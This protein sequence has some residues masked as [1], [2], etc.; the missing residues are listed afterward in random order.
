[1]AVVSMFDTPSVAAPPADVK[2]YCDGQSADT[3]I[4]AQ[5]IAREHDAQRQ[6]S[7]GVQDQETRARC[8]SEW[9]SWQ[10]RQARGGRQGGDSEAVCRRAEPDNARDAHSA[11]TCVSRPAG[12]AVGHPASTCVSR[13]A[14]SRSEGLHIRRRRRRCQGV[15]SARGGARKFPRD[16][17]SAR[18]SELSCSAWPTGGL[19]PVIPTCATRCRNF[20]PRAPRTS[21]S[22]GCGSPWIFAQTAP[23]AAPAPRS[24]ARLRRRRRQMPRGPRPH[25]FPRKKWTQ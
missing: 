19:G 1:M 2:A 16:R 3:T 20:P 7:Q 4:Q 23:P 5:C 10:M 15:P 14:K 24:T 18:S 25:R 22:P 11:G 6:L 17:L 9:Y 8:Y 12:T 13:R 21:W